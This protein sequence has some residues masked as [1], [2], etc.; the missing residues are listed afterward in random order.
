M[1]EA[2]KFNCSE[3]TEVCWVIERS[4]LAVSSTEFLGEYSM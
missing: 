3:C 2:L 1:A 4:M